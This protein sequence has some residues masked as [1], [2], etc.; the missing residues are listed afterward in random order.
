ME[1]TENTNKIKK[2]VKLVDNEI[3][4]IQGEAYLRISPFDDYFMFTINTISGNI[5]IPVDLTGMG[6]FY[7]SFFDTNQEIKIPNYTNIKDLEPTKG[8][9]VF[10]ISKEDS[11]RIL[12]LTNNIF[13]ISNR[14]ESDNQFSDESVLY[15]GKFIKFNE[16]PGV[17]LS[18]KLTKLEESK[19]KEIELLNNK[20]TEL[21]KKL[22]SLE[23]EKVNLSA[24]IQSEITKNNN[25]L[26]GLNS[27]KGDLPSVKFNKITS[28][29]DKN[30]SK[31]VDTKKIKETSKSEKG[32]ES[33]SSILNK[34]NT[35]PIKRID[36]ND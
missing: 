35:K 30:S 33:T 23:L 7:L 12:S 9:V 26:N 15:T 27:I 19:N 20:I 22:N 18:E 32:L 3:P 34:E 13:Y 28:L 31:T 36:T 4:M 21:E 2:I 16:F 10:R 14:M 29:I 8:Q 17:I 1:L 11:K 5:N 6:V 25:L 24:A